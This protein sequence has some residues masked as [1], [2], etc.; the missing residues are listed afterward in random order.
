M[1]SLDYLFFLFV[2]S[3]LEGGGGDSSESLSS[4]Y[5]GAYFVF[6]LSVLSF[7]DLSVAFFVDYYFS[8]LG[9]VTSSSSESY[10]SFIFVSSSS[11]A[12]L[13]ILVFSYLASYF[14]G[15]EASSVGYLEV[16]F[17]LFF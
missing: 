13:V 12:F 15:Y 8:F 17:D 11:L 1:A 10:S 7:S 14:S 16:L 4:F 3:F 2:L 9:G 6:L 5:L